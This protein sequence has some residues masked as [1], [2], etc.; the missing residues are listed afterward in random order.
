[1]KNLFNDNKF[2]KTNAINDDVKTWFSSVKQA[3]FRKQNKSVELFTLKV[4]KIL[5]SDESL[6]STYDNLITITKLKWFEIEQTKKL[7][8]KNRSNKR[9]EKKNTNA[10]NSNINQL[11]KEFQEKNVTQKSTKRIKQKFETKIWK[12]KNDKSKFRKIKFSNLKII[13]RFKKRAIYQ[14]F[15]IISIETNFMLVHTTNV[16]NQK[17]V[18]VFNIAFKLNK[19]TKVNS[20]IKSEL[21]PSAMNIRKNNSKLILS[22]KKRDEFRKIKSINETKDTYMS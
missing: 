11:K 21:K 1:M 14:K 6:S 17:T 5:D 8:I 12:I 10:M 7:K 22:K 20:V 9:K 15:S 18:S 2:V 3:K 13:E 19:L 4:Q 16:E